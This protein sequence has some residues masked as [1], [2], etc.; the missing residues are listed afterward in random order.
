ME[1]DALR[2]PMSMV[3][4]STLLLCGQANSKEPENCF[5]KLTRAPRPAEL[6]WA[7]FPSGPE[8]LRHTPPMSKN[9]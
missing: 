8:C 6:K 1:N 4:L 2:E 9:P 5:V 7:L 3:R